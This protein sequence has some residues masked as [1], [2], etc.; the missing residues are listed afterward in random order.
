MHLRTLHGPKFSRTSAPSKRRSSCLLEH[1]PRLPHRY[2]REA[3]KATLRDT[4]STP[5]IRQP[6]SRPPALQRKPL[7]TRLAFPQ[8]RQA[9]GRKTSGPQEDQRTTGRPVRQERDNATYPAALM[10]GTAGPGKGTH[11]L[12]ILSFYRLID[13]RCSSLPGLVLA[14]SRCPP[15]GRPR[16]KPRSGRRNTSGIRQILLPLSNKSAQRTFT[17]LYTQ[18]TSRTR[19]DKSPTPRPCG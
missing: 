4:N 2:D 16:P 18:M 9:D 7:T 11:L 12:I 8:E 5:P 17:W 14:Y 15:I 6:Y 10:V 3:E 19:I 1:Q 13:Q